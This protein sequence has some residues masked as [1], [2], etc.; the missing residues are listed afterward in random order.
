MSVFCRRWSD[1]VFNVCIIYTKYKNNIDY[2]HKTAISKNSTEFTYTCGMS[3]INK[4]PYTSLIPKKIHDNPE[5]Q[6]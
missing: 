4:T 2:I 5:S 3:G 6:A 1:Y